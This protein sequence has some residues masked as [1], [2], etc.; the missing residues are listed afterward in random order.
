MST[1][2]MISWHFTD[3]V[4][5]MKFIVYALFC[6]TR[7]IKHKFCQKQRSIGQDIPPGGEGSVTIRATLVLGSEEYRPKIR[8]CC[9]H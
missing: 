2:L 3:E 1:C 9:M 4:A 6:I 8:K 5:N 7:I